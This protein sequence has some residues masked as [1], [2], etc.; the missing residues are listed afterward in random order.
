MEIGVF[1]RRREM[2]NVVVLFYC[3][4]SLVVRMGSANVVLIG[5]NVTLSFDDIE[6]NFGE[7]VIDFTVLFGYYF[8]VKIPVCRL[9]IQRDNRSD[10]LNF[11][12]ILGYL[13]TS[14]L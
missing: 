6:A 2:V 13:N 12:S 3:L 4:L 11:I 14:L 9:V 8:L 7:F 10:L 1:V 5:H